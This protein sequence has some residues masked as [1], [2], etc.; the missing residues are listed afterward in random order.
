MNNMFSYLPHILIAAEE[1][2]AHGGADA[3]LSHLRQLS[4]DDFGEFL[5]QLPHDSLPN[6]SG[7][8]PRMASDE[9]Q[10]DWTGNVGIPLL[11]QTT[12]FVRCVAS[13]YQAL[14]GQELNDRTILDFGCGYGRILRLMYYYSAPARIWGVDPWNKSIELCRSDGILGH[15][16]VSDYLP[17]TLPVGDVKFDLIYCFSVFTHLSPRAAIMALATLRRYLLKGGLLVITIRPKEYWD[18]SNDQFTREEMIKQH[19]DHGFAFAPH[20]RAAVDGEVTYGDASLSLDW[21]KQHATDWRM[22][23]YDRNLI[24]PLQI[25]VYL[26]PE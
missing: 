3:A 5:L 21:L 6:L 16:A 1:A 15:L 22:V 25:L 12:S 18:R 14:I 8:L 7:C 13:K 19:D 23:G 10:Q 2:A 9:V 17:S 4:L 26:V 11:Q 20:V 24:D